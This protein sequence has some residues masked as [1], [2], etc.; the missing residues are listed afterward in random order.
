MNVL[1]LFLN[2]VDCFKRTLTHTDIIYATYDYFNGLI[3][4]SNSNKT[5]VHSRLKQQT[6]KEMF[7]SQK[8][9]LH[10]VGNKTTEIVGKLMELKKYVTRRK[11]H[12]KNENARFYCR[13]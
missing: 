13:L 7:T 10:S 8:I 2:F 5:A 9:K 3:K 11:T 6:G 1:N 12:S 4:P